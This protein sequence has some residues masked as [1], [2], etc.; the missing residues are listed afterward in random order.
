MAKLGSIAPKREAQTPASE[1]PSE[2]ELE[3]RLFTDATDNGNTQ[4]RLHAFGGA[5]RTRIYVTDGR[6]AS[7]LSGEILKGTSEDITFVKTRKY[8]DGN[9]ATK[10]EFRDT[11]QDGVLVVLWGPEDYDF[12]SL[13]VTL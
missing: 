7:A 13:K 1:I 6:A 3:P 9:V 12:K 11:M 8:D 4:Y 2:L 10:V 5:I